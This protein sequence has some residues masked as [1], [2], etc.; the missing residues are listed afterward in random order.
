MAPQLAETSTSARLALSCAS[1]FTP[2]GIVPRKRY[3]RGSHSSRSA[4][5]S[6]C[7][8][9]FRAPTTWP[10]ALALLLTARGAQ[11]SALGLRAQ[12]QQHVIVF[13]SFPSLK[14]QG[15]HSTFSHQKH[16]NAKETHQL[17]GVISQTCVPSRAQQGTFSAFPTASNSAI[18]NPIPATTISLPKSTQNSQATADLPMESS[19]IAAAGLPPPSP[20]ER[21]WSPSGSLPPC[22]RKIRVN[23]KY[24][25]L[26]S[27]V[28][29]CASV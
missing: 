7:F 27:S 14:M 9:G 25:C 19:F 8:D 28:P 18:C 6:S 13:I 11:R 10:G 3:Q 16:T 21:L 23:L 2:V 29:E 15:A 1:T 4:K 26:F 24:R 20:P 17:R 5:Q 12:R 22:T